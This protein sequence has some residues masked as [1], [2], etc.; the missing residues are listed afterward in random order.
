MSLLFCEGGPNSPDVRIL[1]KLL[2]G[3]CEVR[4]GGS[5]HGMG[6]RIKARRE[7]L[8]ATQVAGVV[9]GDFRETWP[10]ATPLHQPEHWVGSD[11]EPLGWRWSR[12][13]IENYIV[14]AAVV[15]RALGER[16]PDPQEYQAQLDAAAYGLAAYQAA[17][18]ALS[19]CR[20]RL[21]P[22]PTSWGPERDA[23]RHPFPND[24]SLEGCRGGLRTTVED[25]H[26]RQ[27][28]SP[29]EVLTRY[30]ELLPQFAADGPR[31]R[32]FLWTFAGKD[33]V[34]VMGPGLQTM[35]LGSVRAF[36]ERVLLG[37]ETTADDIAS[38]L[39][40]WG[41]LAAAVQAF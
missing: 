15:S 39:P 35:G 18:T 5:I 1:R 3:R 29:E 40:E 17:R 19:A 27:T 10:T 30:E 21:R 20:R 25:H 13:E 33:L 24:V 34:H 22:M 31:R 14:D 9:D 37:I 2:A 4:P 8:G 32:D 38:W 12:K 41:A 28:V 26:G 11:K 6:D 23:D 16:A 36:K 7:V